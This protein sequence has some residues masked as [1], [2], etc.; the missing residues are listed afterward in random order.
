M[1]NKR[2]L[3]L[4]G[5]HINESIGFNGKSIEELRKENPRVIRFIATLQTVNDVNRNKRYYPKNVLEN[6][7]ND[8][9]IQDIMKRNSFFIEVGHPESLEVRRQQRV[10]EN[11]VCGIIKKIWIEGNKVQG[12]IET[13]ADQKGTDWKDRILHN[14]VVPAFSLRAMGDFDYDASLGANVVKSPM[15]LFSW[16]LV[17]FP[18][19]DGAIMERLTED[20]VIFDVSHN[21][22]KYN[23]PTIFNEGAIIDVP[24]YFEQMKDIQ[25]SK[26]VHNLTES[27]SKNVKKAREFY[28]YNPTDKVVFNENNTVT[29]ERKDLIKVVNTRDYIQKDIAY[30]IYDFL[31][32][33]N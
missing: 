12:L 6:A 13:T 15:A 30:N 25:S 10:E 9:R 32:R 1:T 17:Q 11:N 21:Y 27:Y 2:F 14:G 33:K 19:H 26:R 20:A 7:I 3:I 24:D 22:G 23:T 4:E 29:V 18:S 31:N 28:S 8:P 16:D 5:A